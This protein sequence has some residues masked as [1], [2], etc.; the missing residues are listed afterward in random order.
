MDNRREF[1]SKKHRPKHI[2]KFDH[3]AGC[4]KV[5]GDEVFTEVVMTSNDGMTKKHIALC[6]DC[7]TTAEDYG[8]YE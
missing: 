3:C 4:D 7:D 8:V 1:P 5:I 2:Y 6:R